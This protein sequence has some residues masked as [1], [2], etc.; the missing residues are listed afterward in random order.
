[1]WRFGSENRIAE[2]M[3]ILLACA[4]RVREVNAHLLRLF[5]GPLGFVNPFN[6]TIL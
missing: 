1:M 3:K 2:F 5:L 4:C 6:G